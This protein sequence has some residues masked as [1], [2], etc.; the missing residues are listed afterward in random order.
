[1]KNSVKQE[2]IAHLGW[3]ISVDKSLGIGALVPFGY[4]LGYKEAADELTDKAVKCGLEDLYV[5]P[6][7]FLYRQYL[8]LLLKNMYF[9]YSEDTIQEK[10]DFVKRNGHKISPYWR[11]CKHLLC[12][13][14]TSSDNID[15][16]DSLVNKFEQ[17]DEH[18]FTFRYYLDKE[19]DMTLPKRLFVN[20]KKLKEA[21]DEVD[22]LLYGTYG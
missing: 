5:F 22:D 11:K 21:V 4:I 17:I 1:M 18:S 14:E 9:K 6:I 8:E 19:F 15:K 7:L 3:Q 10:K 2:G 13:N 20:L 12:R 16:I